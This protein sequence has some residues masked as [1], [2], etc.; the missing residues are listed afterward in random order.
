MTPF[1]DSEVEEDA[2]ADLI[3]TLSHL[4]IKAVT[5]LGPSVAGSGRQ[6]YAAYPPVMATA[7]QQLCDGE[8]FDESWE[9]SQSPLV[10]WR[11]LADRGHAG[12]WQR[13]WV[14]GGMQTMVRLSVPTT[15]SRSFEIFVFSSTLFNSRLQAAEVVYALMSVWPVLKEQI[16]K[17]AHQISN[18]EKESL[19]FAAEGL[20]AK[21]TAERMGLTERTVNHHWTRAMLK[22]CAKNKADAV[23]RSIT[24][25]LI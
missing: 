6:V 19:V 14:D 17:D 2:L 20:T 18:R 5:I 11:S 10:A 22:L 1:P 21:E 25:G 12:S 3:D 4:H 24:L 13:S 8:S 23:R 7:A 9:A 15:R 16:T